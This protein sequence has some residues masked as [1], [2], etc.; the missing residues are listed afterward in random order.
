RTL[1]VSFIIV[2]MFPVEAI[3]GLRGPARRRQARCPAPDLSPGVQHVDIL[4]TGAV[5]ARPITRPLSRPLSRQA[6]H[7]AGAV[8]VA[9]LVQPVF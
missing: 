2:D 9:V 7:E 4:G 6:Q 3:C 5:R 8:D 1:D